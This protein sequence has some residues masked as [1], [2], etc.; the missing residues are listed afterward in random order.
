MMELRAPMRGKFKKVVLQRYYCLA[1]EYDLMHS[2]PNEIFYDVVVEITEKIVRTYHYPD[3]NTHI[4]AD[5]VNIEGYKTIE[6]ELV[7][8]HPNVDG[9]CVIGICQDWG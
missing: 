6:C 2:C 8:C 4:V 1:G 5:F 9:T 3:H 7:C